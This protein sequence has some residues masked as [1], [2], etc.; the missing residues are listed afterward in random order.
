MAIFRVFGG[1]LE[2]T[3]QGSIGTRSDLFLEAYSFFLK[4]PISGI[5]LGNFKAYSVYGFDYPHN[6][7]LE[8]FTENGLFIGII[9]LLFIA[10]GLFISK[11]FLRIIIFYFLLVCTFSGDLGYLRFAFIFI[12]LSICINKESKKDDFKY[13]Q[14]YLHKS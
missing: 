2:E 13:S 7:H 5:G 10:Y 12:L 4:N 11:S 6:A 3:D 8:V 9:Y 1:D 14:K